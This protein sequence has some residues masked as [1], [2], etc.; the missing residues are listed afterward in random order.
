MFH[1]NTCVN[2]HKQNKGDKPQRLFSLILYYFNNKCFSYDQIN[3]FTIKS[4]YKMIAY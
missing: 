3:G 2:P 1:R 4:L